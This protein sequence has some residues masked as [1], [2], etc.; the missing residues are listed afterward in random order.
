MIITGSALFIEAHSSDTVLEKIKR[1]PAVT[2]QVMSDSGKELVVNLEAEDHNS[3]EC[4]C[5]E[6]RTEIPEII[7][8]AHIYVNFEEEVEK[9]A[10]DETAAKEADVSGEPVP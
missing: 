2:F 8:I 7:E 3:L 1:F 5:R 10:A 6:L 4:L 9:M